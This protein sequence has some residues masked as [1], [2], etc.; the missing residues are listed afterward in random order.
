MVRKDSLVLYKNRPARVLQTGD[1]LVIEL[2]GG[3]QR[4][5]REKDFLLLHPGPL[6]SLGDLAPV[7]GEIK[8]AWELLLEGGGLDLAS[9]AEF[10]YGE[11]T[12]ATAWAAWQHV[13]DGLYFTGTPEDVR[14]RDPAAVAAEKEARQAQA[15]KAR[16]WIAFLARVETG[17]WLPEEDL[18]FLR[19]VEDFAYRRR[20]DSRVLRE[21]GRKEQPESAHALLLELGYWD[22]TVNPYPVREGVLLTPPALELPALPDEFREDLTHLESFAIDDRDNEDPDDA[23]SLEGERIWVHV[24]DPAAMVS[25]DSAL[26]MEARARGATLYLPEGT[27]PMLPA[28]AIQYLGLGLQEV[29][30]ALSFGMLLG[31]EGEI[32][33]LKIVPSLVRVQRRAYEEVETRLQEEPFRTLHRL[34]TLYQARRAANGALFIDLPETIVRVIDGQVQI[35]PVQPLRSRDLVREAMLMAGEASAG[36]ALQHKLAFPFAVQ[37]ARV[38]SEPLPQNPAAGERRVDLAAAF[39]IRRQLAPGE[40]RTVPGGHAGLG[41]PAYS[42]VTSPL[43]RY[44]DLVAHQQLRAHLS[45]HPGLEEQAL[46]ERIGAADAATGAVNRTERLSRQHWTLVYLLQNP[47]WAGEGVLVDRRGARARLLIPDLA[48]ET[49]I[50]LR[51]DHPLNQVFRLA[52]KSINLPSLE[53]YFRAHPS[54]HPG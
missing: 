3:A 16:A 19:E 44:P 28:R 2:E 12:A 38:I 6:A 31:P 39:A 20:P 18:D 30:P 15:A 23:I 48:M 42:R 36:F 10:I 45:G 17:T 47:N 35:R 54:E 32:E 9:L 52:V 24:A 1:K 4:K 53:A 41:L 46:V 37:E 14:T 33:D 26:E 29:S 50:H 8:T 25:P 7:P 27:V 34:A 13:A 5:V 11:N 40:V 51:G 22:S 49:D 21:L 43:R